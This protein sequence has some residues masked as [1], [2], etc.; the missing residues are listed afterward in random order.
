MPV[1]RPA[2]S[3]LGGAQ[4]DKLRAGLLNETDDGMF[5]RF[6]FIWPGPPPV[7]SLFDARKAAAGLA[8]LETVFGD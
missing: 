1:P 8:S 3:L 4:P 7:G 2:L 5:S 6:D